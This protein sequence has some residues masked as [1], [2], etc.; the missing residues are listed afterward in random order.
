M[1]KIAFSSQGAIRKSSDTPNPELCFSFKF[2]D[3][4]D[5]ELCPPLFREN[6]T[7]ILMERLRGLSTWTVKEFTSTTSKSIRNHAHDWP[8]PRGQMGLRTCQSI[9]KVHKGGSFSCLL[10]SMAVYTES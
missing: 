3:S 1:K 4:S 9:F 5:S 10:M 2:F 7:Q 8:K 6:Y